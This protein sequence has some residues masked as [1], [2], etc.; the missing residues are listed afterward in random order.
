MKTWFNN[1][2]SGKI[3]LITASSLCITTI[4]NANE[5]NAFYPD[6]PYYGNDCCPCPSSSCNP[7]W[8]S[9]DSWLLVGSLL[10]GAA[11]GAAAGAA[12]SHGKRGK[13][14]CNGDPGDPGVTGATGSTG[15]TGPAGATGATGV[16]G[17]TG[18]AG[19]DLPSFPSFLGGSVEQEAQ[20][21][22]FNYNA[23]VSVSTGSGTVT[24]IT[25]VAD[26]NGTVIQSAPTKI[27]GIGNVPAGSLPTIAIGPTN[28]QYGR[29]T[30]GLI[31][32]NPNSNVLTI[33]DLGIAIYSTRPPA[34]TTLI[35]EVGPQGLLSDSSIQTSGE[36]IYGT[37]TP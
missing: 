33:S 26:P 21:L 13:H 25:Y 18:P 17:A 29:Y 6:Q 14:G 34:D 37:D 15:A 11:A 36:F 20:A 30:A 23:G 31:I 28:L 16:T 7:C 22:Y 24:V 2:I 8:N 27:N 5:N 9:R 19:T 1:V 32:D 10:V 4:G 35:Y 3:A 12:T